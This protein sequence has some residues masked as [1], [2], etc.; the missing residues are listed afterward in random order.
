MR[1]PRFQQRVRRSGFTLV[2]SMVAITLFAVLG[3][4]LAVAVSIGN[5]SQKMVLNVASEDR[6]LR[7]ATM[8]LMQELRATQDSSIALFDLPDA[9]TRLTFQMPIDNAGVAAWGVYDKSLGATAALQNR[10]G[11]KVRY[12]V[13]DVTAV[14]GR[15]DK[16]LVRQEL[17]AAD[18]VQKEKV[19]I[20]GLRP[21]VA[22]E[23]F[24][25]V[26]QGLVWQVTLSTT[27]Q[28][29]G[30]AGI[31]TVFHVQTRN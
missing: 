9:N 24:K 17:D 21:G 1:S 14:G 10:V 11:W 28:G 19:L 25:V 30:Q 15:V 13:R 29:E 8:T 22:P 7:S 2:E 5:H 23:G 4:A 20:H 3:Y 6:G 26:Q 27:S 18:A 16:V 31:R 12:T